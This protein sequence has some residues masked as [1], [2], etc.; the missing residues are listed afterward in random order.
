MPTKNHPGLADI[1]QM[2]LEEH[3]VVRRGTNKRQLVLD[4]REPFGG[5]TLLRVTLHHIMQLVGA[6]L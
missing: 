6:L 4:T 5:R 3:A 1:F 2:P